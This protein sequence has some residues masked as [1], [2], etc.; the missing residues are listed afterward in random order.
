V[1]EADDASHLTKLVRPPW[2]DYTFAENY[3]LA[4]TGAAFT[5][6]LHMAET[7]THEEQKALQLCLEK[8]KIYA[9]MAPEHKTILVEKLQ[10]RGYL[11]GMCGDGANDCGALK[12]ADV[13]V[14]LSE[15]DSSI[16]APFTS[17]VADISSVLTVLK[18]G[19]CALTTSIQCFKY[20]A[21]Y[22][23][24]QFTSASF[25]YWYLGNLTD[26]QFLLFDLITVMP[27]A[28]FMS[29]TGPYTELS[30]HQPPSELI[31]LRILSSV[32][33]QA[34]LQ[35]LAQMG[36]YV[37]ALETFLSPP[38]VVIGEDPGKITYQNTV[39]V[40]MSWFQYQIMC[41]VFS[42]GKPWKKPS[43]TNYYL[44]SYQIIMVTA[45]AL[46]LFLQGPVVSLLINVII[47]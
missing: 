7:E 24:I 8:C 14:S 23:L 10:T 3:A 44:T 40:L 2:I 32:I 9:R 36:A 12:T 28:V 38:D 42:I 27:L 17:Q 37:L 22:S 20:M 1:F 25:L 39:I 43:Y 16:A 30:K 11:V 18:E 47:I 26:N 35:A 31:S 15:A 29:M 33:F 5:K 45:S 46:A 19:R 34:V 6:I 21:L 41:F 13:G 4:L